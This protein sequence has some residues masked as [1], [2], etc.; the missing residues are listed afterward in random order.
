MRYVL[1]V[2]RSEPTGQKLH[3]FEEGE[4]R[5]TYDYIEKLTRRFERQIANKRVICYPDATGKREYTSSTESDHDII[6]AAGIT[7]IT[8]RRNPPIA[9]VVAHVNN[10]FHT[11]KIAVNIPKCT[12]LIRCCEQWGYGKDLKPEKGGTV[13]HS[14]IG[15]AFKYLVW[16]ALPRAASGLAARGRW[17]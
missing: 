2:I 7:I 12:D 9:S 15:D 11:D 10:C 14:N 6:R 8:E 5:D 4:A 1:A 3:I 17:R 16:G 13:D